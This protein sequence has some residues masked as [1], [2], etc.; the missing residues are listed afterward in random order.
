MECVA[1]WLPEGTQWC[2]GCTN[3]SKRNE[4][5]EKLGNVLR[6]AIPYTTRDFSEE[7]RAAFFASCPGALFVKKQLALRTDRPMCLAQRAPL[8]R[9][10]LLHRIPLVLVLSFGLPQGA[11][12]DTVNA[13]IG[14][15]ANAWLRGTSSMEPNASVLLKVF[16]HK[17]RVAEKMGGHAEAMRA[18]AFAH[19]AYAG[20]RAD[21]RVRLALSDG[22]PL[23]CLGKAPPLSRAACAVLALLARHVEGSRVEP[24]MAACRSLIPKHVCPLDPGVAREALRS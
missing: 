22:G 13:W 23:M 10:F 2:V 7:A 15:A 17:I 19:A 4:G 8:L 24:F 14:E 16:A 18:V 1:P 21:A 11:T 12:E 20:L 9:E 3:V 5:A 6:D